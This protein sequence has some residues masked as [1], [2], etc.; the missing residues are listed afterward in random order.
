MNINPSIFRGYDIRGLVDEDLNPQILNALGKAYGTFL[1][2]RQIN[3]CVVGCDVRL[4]SEEY[5]KNFIE[6]LLE[7]GINVVDFGLALTQIMYFAQ[8]HYLSK[9][10]AMITASHNPKEFNGLKLAVGFS[11]TLVTQEIQELRS[12]AES[13]SFEGWP[14]RGAYREDN[15]FESY[16]K[17]LFKRVPLHDS[18]L[19]VVIDSMNATTGIFLPSILREAGCEVVEKNTELDGSFP[20]GT[21]DPTEKDVLERLGGYVREAKADL[22]VSYDSD[23]DRVGVVDHEGNI[24]WNDVLVALFA[25]DIL[26][27]LPNSPIVFNALCSKT[28]L[29]TIE[30]AGGKPIMWK[31]GHSFIKAK[32][33]EERAPFGGE[34]SGHFFF[35]DN[36]YGHDD[37][38]FATLRLL[39]YLKRVNK[40]LKDVVDTLPK[41]ISSPE[42]KLGLGDDIKFK[43]I[44][45][46]FAKDIRELLPEASFVDIDGIR[47]DTENEMVIIRASQN[48]P[49]ITIKFEG[50][51]QEQ[52]DSLKT[53]I[54]EILHKYKEVD[55][56]E[57]VNIHAFDS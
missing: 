55:W 48:G 26:H 51:T 10:G 23:G 3:E 46:H 20:I 39:S 12:I 11:D 33:K 15:V 32:V 19:K 5:K 37:G 40:S 56:A 8:Y 16:K 4:T 6:G 53:K 30:Q 50:R 14:T 41:Y 25:Q 34:L 1:H 54:A 21:P 57:G 27:F 35:M 43:F 49:Y 31:T 29:N 42:I 24:L 18:G 28:T 13:E 17:D 22:G 45:E 44:E 36:F 7:M 9:G 52:Y 47:A 2:R 38:A